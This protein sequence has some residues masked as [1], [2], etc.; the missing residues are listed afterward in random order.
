MISAANTLAFNRHGI[1]AMYKFEMA[2]A[3][4][5]ISDSSDL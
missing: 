5:T 1:W 4:R 2:R 3:L